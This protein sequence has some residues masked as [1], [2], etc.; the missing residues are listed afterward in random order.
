MSYDLAD[1]RR[2]APKLTLDTGKPLKLEGF[3]IDILRDHFGQA[4]ELVVVIP[5]KNYK[6][7]TMAAL[8]L[9]HLREVF[10]ADVPILAASS[11]QAGIMFRQ[12]EKL[13]VNSGEKDPTRK[14]VWRLDGSVYEIRKGYREI[15]CN[16][17]VL[18][19]VANDSDTLDGV[20]PTLGLIDELHRHRNAENYG[21]ISDGLGPR[22]GR[23]ITISTA[24]YTEDSPLGMLR[25]RAHKYRNRRSKGRHSRY[26]EG[27]TVLHEW[28][29]D[30]SKGDDPEN[31][32]DVKMANPAKTQTLRELKRRRADP[33]MTTGRWLRFAGGIW[34]AGEE[35]EIMPD[36]WD[37]LRAE[38]GG[39]VDGD[40]VVLAPSVGS[41]AV[42]AIASLRGDKI[43]VAAVHLE[44]GGSIMARTEDAIVELC[45]R[46]DVLKV[47][48]PGY[49]MQ[50]S[51]QLVEARGVPVESA[52]YSTPRQIAATGT[53]DRYMRAGDLIHD[54]D[55]QTRAHVL[56]ALK[57][58]GTN[59]EHYIASD[60]TRAIVAMAQA[61]H[62]ASA[63]GPPST[64][65]MIL[66]STG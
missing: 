55:P 58:T 30:L 10:Q 38:I 3:Q 44:A 19:V 34:T 54:G 32:H 57:K 48:D 23:M 17:G 2:W 16:G 42:I 64:L 7:T 53:F 9:F 1:F 66:P 22:K 45:E 47:L 62:S 56:S 5:K 6:T 61:V 46:Y 43:A 60:S 39:V 26:A 25:T 24:G 13:I 28:A 65:T 35:P 27:V 41:S 49:G 12:A 31:F 8:G 15:R 11:K 52:P 14:D 33:M 4:V 36:E 51:M 63:D 59:G 50:R 20:I 37:A 21:L 29:L 18:Y 40:E